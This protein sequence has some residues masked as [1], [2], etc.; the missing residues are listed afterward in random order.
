MGR[1][2]TRAAETISMRRMTPDVLDPVS[3]ALALALPALL[4]LGVAVMLHRG[5][6]EPVRRERE[7]L[8]FDVRP[9]AITYWADI[10][11]LRARWDFEQVEMEVAAF[12]RERADLLR[13]ADD[14]GR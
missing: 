2:G 10:A 14:G 9:G 8:A 6:P 7:S 5:L 13:W 4:M 12:V 1:C 11:E 3:A